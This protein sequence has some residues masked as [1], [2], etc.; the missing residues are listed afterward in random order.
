MDKSLQYTQLM[1]NFDSAYNVPPNL[2]PQP[3]IYIPISSSAI[4]S[5]FPNRP[6][7]P[8]FRRS[9]SPP[10]RPPISTR[11]VPKFNFDL[12]KTDENLN[13]YNDYFSPSYR[14]ISPSSSRTIY[15]YPRQSPLSSPTSRSQTLSK[16]KQ[17]NDELCH[18]LARSELTDQSSAP[19]YHIH[20]YPLSQ[21]SYPKYRSRSRSGERSSSTELEVV[22]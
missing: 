12:Y 3:T 10:S 4:Y 11:P 6:S 20:H 17:V 13:E 1:S 15:H 22:I 16:L 2:T 5:T 18:T 7:S 8:L 14:S 19:H 9:K 21:H